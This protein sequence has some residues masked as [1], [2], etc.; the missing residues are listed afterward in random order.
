MARRIRE[1]PIREDRILFEIVVDAYNESERAMGW[2]CYLQDHLQMPFAAVC[3]SVRPTS[4]LKIGDAVEVLA[5]AS[6][7]D[8]ISEVCVVVKRGRSELAVPLGQLECLSQNE[9]TS[10]GIEDWHYW[11]QRGYQY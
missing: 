7:H 4:P 10:R 11:Q 6:E 8:C 2:Y 5:L 9:D 1:D 3:R